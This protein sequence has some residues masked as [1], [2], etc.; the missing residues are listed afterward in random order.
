MV[1]PCGLAM[2]SMHHF[3][4]V[5]KRGARVFHWK[6][7][8]SLLQHPFDLVIDPFFISPISQ[9]I[10]AEASPCPVGVDL[11][12]PLVLVHTGTKLRSQDST[13]FKQDWT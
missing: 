6:V 1:T 2:F 9:V 12:I 3:M 7:D 8:L 5:D 10:V 4:L 11:L 13:Q